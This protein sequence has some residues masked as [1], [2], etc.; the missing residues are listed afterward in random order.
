MLAFGDVWVCERCK[1]TFVQKLKEGVPI[2][3]CEGLVRQLKSQGTWRLLFLGAVTLGIYMAHYIKRQTTVLNQH[4]DS[5]DAISEGLVTSILIFQYIS[6]ILSV[7]GFVLGEGAPIVLFMIGNLLSMILV[8]LVV[9]W[10]FKS[11]NRMNTLLS[12]G[13]SD[14]RWFSGCYTFLFTGLYFNYKINELNAQLP[15]QGDAPSG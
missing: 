13:K 11:R 8:V 7:L 1:P 2:Q 15:E 6:A 14:P 9:V 5:E 3:E 4:L 10:A 12:V